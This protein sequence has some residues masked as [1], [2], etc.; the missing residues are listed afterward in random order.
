MDRLNELRSATPQLIADV[1]MFR[2][3]H[4]GRNI[5]ALLGWC[6]PLMLSREEPLEGWTAWPLLCDTS[7]LPGYVRRLG[8]VF[9]NPD[10]PEKFLAATEFYLWEMRFVGRAKVVS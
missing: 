1:E 8:F 10:G 7:F 5:P 4:G 6:C 3:A 2:P 9:A